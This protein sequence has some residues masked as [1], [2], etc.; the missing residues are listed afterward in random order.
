MLSVLLLFN[1]SLFASGTM[2]GVS[3]I[4]PA[5]LAGKILD[6]NGKL[7]TEEVTLSAKVRLIKGVSFERGGG[8]E[9]DV[10]YKEYTK[11]VSGGYFTWDIPKATD[12][13]LIVSKDGYH[14]DDI[15]LKNEDPRIQE[16]KITDIIL[17]L[18]PKGDPVDLEWTYNA[19]IS[20]VENQITGWSFKRRWYFPVDNYDVL[21][22]YYPKNDKGEIILEMKEGGGFIPAK[23]YVSRE[24][25]PDYTWG[26]FWH[27][28]EAPEMGYEQRIIFTPEIRKDI[29]IK[30][31]VYYYFRTPDGKYGKM[32][33]TGW[34]KKGF[35][36]SYYLNPTGGRSLE[37]KEIIN[38][39][40]QN[41]KALDW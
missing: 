4:Y 30:Q 39:Y 37:P 9:A 41:P 32:E 22:K 2:P 7:F 24:S 16:I 34:G 31:D 18:I 17:H 23:R 6:E 35:N 19:Y 25:N 26:S 20:P 10:E 3:I 28:T 1:M 13:E 11:K 12:V 38:K 27:M 5:K 33:I 15:F 40:P 36:F 8:P 14:Q 21:M 29:L